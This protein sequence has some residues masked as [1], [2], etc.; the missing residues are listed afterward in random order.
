MNIFKFGYDMEV[1]TNGCMGEERTGK[2][3]EIFHELKVSKM[4]YNVA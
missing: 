4:S 2:H 1:A 3:G